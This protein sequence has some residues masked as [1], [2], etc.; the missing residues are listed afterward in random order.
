MAARRV[1]YLFEATCVEGE[2]RPM[3]YEPL[4]AISS[5][6]SSVAV[7]DDEFL[8]I[9][10][11]SLPNPHAPSLHYRVAVEPIDEVVDLI[12]LPCRD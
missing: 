1:G 5:A 10:R 12:L 3:W 6:V 11:C 4:R 7:V 8:Q 9:L 2:F